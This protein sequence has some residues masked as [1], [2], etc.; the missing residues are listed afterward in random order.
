M[1][2]PPSPRGPV[3]S[4]ALEGRHV[5]IIACGWPLFTPPIFPPTPLIRGA[6]LSFYKRK[7]ARSRCRRSC[8][9]IADR[10]TRLIANRHTPQRFRRERIIPS[11]LTSEALMIIATEASPSP[12]LFALSMLHYGCSY[13]QN[14]TT[15]GKLE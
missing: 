2:V 1:P 9:L 13:P 8:S 7:S 3:P 4:H 14:L 15:E 12:S 10:Y 5:L 6:P 11:P